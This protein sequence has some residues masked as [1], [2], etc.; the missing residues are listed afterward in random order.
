MEAKINLKV[1]S[2]VIVISLIIFFIIGAFH[3]ED[4]DMSIDTMKMRP[5]MD[6]VEIAVAAGQFTTLATALEAADLINT[7]K[8]PGP[9]TVFAPTDKAFANLPEGTL[10]NLFKTE[11]KDT[12]ADIL[13]HH[14]IPEKVTLKRRGLR[15]LNNDS[16]ILNTLGLTTVN[17]AMIIARDIPATNGVIHIIDTVLI[18]GDNEL[19]R[20]AMKIIN[21]AIELGVPL[22]NGRNEQACAA[23]YESA[24]MDI[25]LFPADVISAKSKKKIKSVLERASKTRDPSEKAWALRKV[26][27]DIN[28]E[29]QHHTE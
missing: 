21:T 4:S 25:K 7:L 3:D 16:L 12:L 6:I 2:S 22:Y 24:L 5:D 17:N 11:N 9:F 1:L 15:T 28:S 23:I 19:R 20:T 29:L 26:L 14:V 10:E 8:Q 13:K 18:P 27:D